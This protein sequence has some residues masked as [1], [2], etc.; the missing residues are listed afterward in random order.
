MVSSNVS[1][2][3]REKV[4]GGL[5]IGRI[6]F[7][8]IGSNL[9]YLVLSG[10]LVATVGLLIL[11]MVTLVVRVLPRCVGLAMIA[12][13]PPIA[14]FLRP[15][16]GVPWALVGYAIFRAAARQTEQPSRVR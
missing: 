14:L 10:I 9:G 11:A 3:S 5:R 8:G 4:L 2:R 7:T 6:L 16:V 12:G 15:L 13:I 1:S